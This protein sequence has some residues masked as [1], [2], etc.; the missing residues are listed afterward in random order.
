MDILQFRLRNS[1]WPKDKIYC[2]TCESQSLHTRA[3]T[4]GTKASKIRLCGQAL[5][6]RRGAPLTAA[7]K[8][9]LNRRRVYRREAWSRTVCYHERISLALVG[10]HRAIRVQTT[11]QTHKYS[12]RE[13]RIPAYQSAWAVMYRTAL[14]S[15]GSPPLWHHWFF[16]SHSCIMPKAFCL[17][18]RYKL[19]IHDLNCCIC[20]WISANKIVLSTNS[21][22][23]AWIHWEPTLNRQSQY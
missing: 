7:P 12:P 21:L 14:L 6:S 8:Q 19:T 16:F 18:Q 9:I 10:T 13:I 22:N 23:F 17:S 20:I 3:A 11:I 4:A 2:I 1:F 5:K 15:R